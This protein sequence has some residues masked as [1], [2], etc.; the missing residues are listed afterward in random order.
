MDGLTLSSNPLYDTVMDLYP[1]AYA[2]KWS[3]WQAGITLEMKQHFLS[4]FFFFITCIFENLEL[5]LFDIKR[6]S[7]L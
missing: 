3:L 6:L 4:F 5:N 1:E 2:M 7:L